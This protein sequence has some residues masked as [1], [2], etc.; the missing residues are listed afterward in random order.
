LEPLVGEWMQALEISSY[1]GGHEPLLV[2][3]T[4]RR[5]LQR[6]ALEAGEIAILRGQFRK[7]RWKMTR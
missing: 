4:L 5:L 7:L 6:A 3:S 2:Q 1:L